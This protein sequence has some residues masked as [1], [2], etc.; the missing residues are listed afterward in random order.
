MKKSFI[1]IVFLFLVVAGI[2]FSNN[3]NIA[4]DG[5]VDGEVEELLQGQNEVSVIVVL[6]DDYNAVNDFSAS[7]LK[8]ED[9][10]E[11]KK[12]MI[13]KQQEKVL[14]NLNYEEASLKNDAT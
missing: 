11:K 7:S 1:V 2:A 12:L 6:E 8:K 4:N 13:E 3:D 14:S 10:F 5:K 9:G